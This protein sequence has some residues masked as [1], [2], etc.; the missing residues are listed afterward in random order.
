MVSWIPIPQYTTM[1]SIASCSTR[2]PPGAYRPRVLGVMTVRV[3]P[4]A[5]TKP[6]VARQLLL[7]STLYERDQA[8]VYLVLLREYLGQ[9][10]WLP[11]LGHL[12]VEGIDAAMS[13]RIARRPPA[14]EH[15]R[16]VRERFFFPPGDV[17]DDVPDRPGPGDPWLHQLRIRQA[18]IGLLKV[19]PCLLDALHQLLPTHAGS[20]RPVGL[21]PL[22]RSRSG[23][24]QRRARVF[25]QACGFDGC[26][27]GVRHGVVPRVH[28]QLGHAGGPRSRPLACST[29]P[30]YAAAPDSAAALSPAPLGSRPMPRAT[31]ASGACRRIA[32]DVSSRARRSSPGS[33][34]KP[35]AGSRALCSNARSISS[36]RRLIA[37][38]FRVTSSGLSN[39]LK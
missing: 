9:R 38:I 24:M 19:H 20:L 32:S 2:R 39:T 26:A 4:Q 36:L 12:G 35:L 21:N 18:G 16:Q 8:A 28:P 29:C 25:E 14:G 34:Y 3:E 15:E 23:L 11:L 27:V 5:T 17:R 1:V 7:G 22:A 30:A 31:Q 6:R 37:S 10:P 33:V 13:H